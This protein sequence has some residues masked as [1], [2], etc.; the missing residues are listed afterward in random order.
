MVHSRAQDALGCAADL[1][2]LLFLHEQKKDVNWLV[3]S[4]SADLR[5]TVRKNALYSKGRAVTVP[6]VTPVCRRPRARALLR[7]KLSAGTKGVLRLMSRGACHRCTPR[8]VRRPRTYCWTPLVSG[9]YSA[10][11]TT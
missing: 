6:Q 5:T 2:K 10:P 7:P 8:S 11:A 3:L 4:D 9:G 1:E